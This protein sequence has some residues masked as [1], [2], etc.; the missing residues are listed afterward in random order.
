MSTAEPRTFTAYQ[1]F[2]K[3]TLAEV[4]GKMLKSLKSGEKWG[5]ANQNAAVKEVG[6]RW[7]SLSDAQKQKFAGSKLTTVPKATGKRKRAAEAKKAKKPRKLSAYNLFVRERSA[8]L[9][10]LESADR[11]KKIGGEWKTLSARKKTEYQNRADEHN[12]NQPAVVE[13][14]APTKGKRAKRAS[15]EPRAL[16]AYQAF[17]KATLSEVKGKM[18]SKK[19]SGEK[20][21][22]TDQN[23]AV[24]EVGARWRKMT[25]AQKQKFAGSKQQTQPAGSANKRKAKV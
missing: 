16:S 15:S 8:Q 14:A 17:F 12:A 5:S 25:D 7:R 4:K 21:G 19:K 18:L 1:A 23:A 10:S 3:K 22:V 2:F 13:E 24:K 11:M 9:Q 6:A 20:W